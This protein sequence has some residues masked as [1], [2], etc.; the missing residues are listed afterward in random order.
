MRN[1]VLLLAVMTAALLMAACSEPNVQQDKAHEGMSKKQE[2]KLNQRIA[3]LEDKVNDQSAEQPTQE[4]QSAEDA[5]LAAAQDYY[6]A[7]AGGNYSSLGCIRTF[8]G[9][10]VS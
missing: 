2:K 4:A 6:A 7:A 10:S 3:E 5:A 1:K 9:R 8:A